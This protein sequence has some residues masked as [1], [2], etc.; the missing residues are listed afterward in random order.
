M[1]INLVVRL[2]VVPPFIREVNF[3]LLPPLRHAQYL[4]HSDEDVKEI[5]L[6]R[7]GFVYDI[8]LD[9]STLR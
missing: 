4:H 6:K 7:N 3:S 2:C 9:Q 5:Q 1:Q 8:L